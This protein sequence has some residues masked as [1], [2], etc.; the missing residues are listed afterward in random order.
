MRDGI[1]K[2]LQ[3]KEESIGETKIYLGRHM[4]KVTLE[5]GQ[6]AWAFGYSQ[7]YQAAVASVE[8]FL[9][10]SGAK[11]PS[12]SDTPIQTSYRP[13]LEISAELGP[14]EEAYFNSLIGILRW[15]IELGRVEICL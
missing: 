3:L 11:L 12:L 1:G 4:R 10:E 9:A 8:T 14:T 7:Y 2:Y 6:D 13:E 15:I 5:N